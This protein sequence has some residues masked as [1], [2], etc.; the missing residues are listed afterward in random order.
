MSIEEAKARGMVFCP[1]C[2]QPCWPTMASHVIV[3]NAKGEQF[4][5]HP[6]CTKDLPR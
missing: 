1:L 6:E 5:A 2:A 4:A 3:E